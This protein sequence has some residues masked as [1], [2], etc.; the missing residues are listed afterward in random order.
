MNGTLMQ[1]CIFNRCLS[2]LKVVPL[3][4]L[5]VVDKGFIFTC[6]FGF[7]EGLIGVWE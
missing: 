7:V 5:F 1:T 3:K 6:M 4:K 2:L